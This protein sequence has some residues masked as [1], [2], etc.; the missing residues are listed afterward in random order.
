PSSKECLKDALQVLGHSPGSIEERVTN[1]LMNPPGDV[2]IVPAPSVLGFD[3]GVAWLRAFREVREQDIA[4][5]LTDWAPGRAIRVARLGPVYEYR[6]TQR[7]AQVFSDI[8]LRDDYEG[9]LKAYLTARAKV[10]AGTAG[11]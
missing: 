9:E 5:R 6:L 10:I 3:F 7:L 2:L 8:G 11:E 1:G 4:S